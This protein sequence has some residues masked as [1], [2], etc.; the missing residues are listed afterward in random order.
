MSTNNINQSISLYIPFVFPNITEKRIGNVF[1]HLGL[2][3]VERVDFVDKNREDDGKPF[4]MAFIHFRSWYVNESVNNIHTTLMTSDKS[5]SKIVYD[6]P[7]FWNVYI[8]KKPRSVDELALERELAITKAVLQ[9]ESIRANYFFQVASTWNNVYPENTLRIHQSI[10]M[11][12][13]QPV[14]VDEIEGYGV[15]FALAPN[16]SYVQLSV[17]QQAGTYTTGAAVDPCWETCI[18]STEEECEVVE[19]A[20]AVI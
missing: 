6:D 16:P 1:H 4:K 15:P 5:S 12:A 18:A 3:D 9:S 10:P 2:G 7:W 20:T 19:P 11:V 13:Y 8:N 17:Q 14:D